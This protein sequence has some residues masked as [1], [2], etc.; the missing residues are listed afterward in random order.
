MNIHGLTA[1][2]VAISDANG[3]SDAP[4]MHWR[5]MNQLVDQETV[6]ITSDTG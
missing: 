5:V 2:I 1:I 3:A 6:N 4:L